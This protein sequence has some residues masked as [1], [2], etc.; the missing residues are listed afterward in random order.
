M[1]GKEKKFVAYDPRYETVG[2][3]GA[4]GRLLNENGL[5]Q[6]NAIQP[7]VGGTFNDLVTVTGNFTIGTLVQQQNASTAVLADAS[8]KIAANSI[9]VQ[10]LT[11]NKAIILPIAKVLVPL[12]NVPSISGFQSLWLG[13]LGNITG[14]EPV[15]GYSQMIGWLNYFDKFHNLYS[16]TFVPNAPVYIGV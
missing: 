6:E 16:V 15:A 3:V 13:N 11:S 7:I 12:V 1:P 9:I 8:R 4:L 5:R 14:V 2:D 10:A